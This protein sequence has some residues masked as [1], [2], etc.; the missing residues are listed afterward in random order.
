MWQPLQPQ[1]ILPRLVRTNKTTLVSMILQS[2]F[3]FSKH[4]VCA[5]YSF[6]PIV[7]TFRSNTFTAGIVKPSVFGGTHRFAR[8]L[9]LMY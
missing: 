7:D 8:D 6:T 5:S 4:A 2:N 3:S 9:A 1:S